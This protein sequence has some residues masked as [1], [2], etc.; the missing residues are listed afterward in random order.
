[1]NRCAVFNAFW[2][3]WV[4]IRPCAQAGVQNG[5]TVMIGD[6]ELEWQD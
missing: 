1:M 5:D 4:W 3:P 2:R 6:F